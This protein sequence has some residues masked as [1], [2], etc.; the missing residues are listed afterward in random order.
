MK[1]IAILIL[2]IVGMTGC[3]KKEMESFDTSY[4]INVVS[5]EDGSGTRGA[6]VELFEVEQDN[7]DGIKEDF[8]TVEA[9][10]TSNTSVMLTKVAGDEYTIGYVSLGSF[11]NSVKA[12]QI[13][14]MDATEENIKNGTYK[15]ARSFNVVTKGEVSDVASDFI[16]FILSEEGQK[17]VSDTGYV[18]LNTSSPYA[19]GKLKGK[20]VIAGSSSVSPV[21]EKLKEAY[22]EIN[23]NIEIEIQANDSSTGISMIT[24][25]TCDIGIASRDLKENEVEKG[26]EATVIARD[27]IVVIVNHM[28]PITNMTAKEVGK[29]F[30]G[31]YPTWD[32][33]IPDERGG[34]R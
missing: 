12:V 28:N 16:D 34:L 1:W 29:V 21:I 11:N 22:L 33:I 9:E 15:A 2:T 10:I 24:E 8:T 14:G 19:S 3:G 23:P 7:A 31:E 20:I 26:L 25:G 30:K 6:F 13:D 4:E 17:V 27:G 5:R 32:K 18:P